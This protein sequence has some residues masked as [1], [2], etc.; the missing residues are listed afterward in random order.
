[1][2]RYSF[3]PLHERDLDLVVRWLARPHVARWWP[4]A[5]RQEEQI[6]RWR[7]EPWTEPYLILLDCRPI[8]FIQTYDPEPA[9]GGDGYGQPPGTRGIDLFIGGADLIGLGH[10]SAV[11]RQM[12]EQLLAE[13]GVEQ[14]IG[15][16]APDNRASIRAFE[17]AGFRDV[18][19]ID[20]PDGP[21]RLMVLS[22]LTGS[23]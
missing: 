2:T 18:G 10:G 17:K 3:Q 6:R 8:G 14:V 15:D 4:D 7:E 19:E 5:K 13:T 16:P 9:P 20:L 1:M 22:G 12:A 23:G 11:I 21:A